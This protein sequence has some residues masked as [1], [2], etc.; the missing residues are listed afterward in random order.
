MSESLLAL[1]TLTS[2]HRLTI[3]SINYIWDVFDS[4]GGYEHTRKVALAS[5][6]YAITSMM[7]HPR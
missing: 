7:A 4:A 2:T 3:L 5:T 1:R 6:Y